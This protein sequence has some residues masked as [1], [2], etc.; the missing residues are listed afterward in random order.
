MMKLR[1]ANDNMLPDITR[2]TPQVFD[3]LLNSVKSMIT[4]YIR[5]MPGSDLTDRMRTCPLFSVRS[6]PVIIG[7]YCA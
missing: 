7:S 4:G 2:M 1:Q 3:D 5:F 6:E